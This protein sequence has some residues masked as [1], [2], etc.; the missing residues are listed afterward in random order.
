MLK[1]NKTILIA[2]AG[3][4]HNGDSKKIIKLIKIASEANVDFVKFQSFKSDK[5]VTTKAKVANYQKKNTNYKF[6]IDLLKKLEL[7]DKQYTLIINTCKKY[8]VKPLFTPFDLDSLTYLKKFKLNYFKVG[9]SDID[10]VQLLKELAKLKKTIFLSTGMSKLYDIKFSLDTLIKHGQ[11]K[12]KIYVLHCNT[13]YPTSFIDVNLNAMQTIRQKFNVK[14]GYS[15]HTLGIEVPIAAASLGA[16]VIEKHFTVNKNLKGPDHK[17]SLDKKELIKMVSSIRN[18]EIS[19]GS[20]LKKITKSEL[21]NI[22]KVKKSIY[23]RKE[24]SKGE[25]FSDKNL[26]IKRPFTGLSGKN[27]DKLI[28]KISKK[29]YKKDDKI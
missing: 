5:L 18:I 3:V 26:I 7:K 1:K 11:S 10:N 15:D 19:L 17:A 13:D 22:S 16:D 2:E 8:K 6:Q 20:K 27:W 25:A 14:V 12:N 4:N 9:S 21:K 24:I 29:N 28:G 23:A